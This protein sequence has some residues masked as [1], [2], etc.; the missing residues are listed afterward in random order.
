M[1]RKLSSNRYRLFLTLLVSW[2]TSSFFQTVVNKMI[3]LEFTRL[4]DKLSSSVLIFCAFIYVAV[5][6]CDPGLLSHIQSPGSLVSYIYIKGNLV[7][8]ID[9]LWEVQKNSSQR[10][11]ISTSTWFLFPKLSPDLVKVF[12][13]KFSILGSIKNK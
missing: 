2:V 13:E 11:I 4:F 5:L 3:P 9:V 1:G 10:F 6:D 8:E 7:T 12:A